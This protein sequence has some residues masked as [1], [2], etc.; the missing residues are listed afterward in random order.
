[1]KKNL[2]PL[3]SDT[4]FTFCTTAFFSFCVARFY[5]HSA[6]AAFAVSAIT[7]LTVSSVFYLYRR[8][9]QN[10]RYNDLLKTENTEKFCFHLA[11]DS[12]ESNTALVA[13]CLFPQ[14][15]REAEPDGGTHE[16]Q[17]L[18]PQ[19]SENEIRGEDCRVWVNF[20][21]EK[22]GAD[23]LAPAIR[24]DCEN[25]TIYANGFT[26]DAIRLA[27]AFGIRLKTGTDLYRIAEMRGLVPQNMLTPPEKTRSV[28]EKLRLRIRRESWKGY[29]LSGC[30]MLLFSLF[31]VFPVYYLVSGGILLFVCAL[32]RFFG[33]KTDE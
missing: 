30:L 14:E 2:I 16:R 25:K 19:I 7:A 1:M 18:P 24:T 26:D 6:A 20:S 23:A 11:A 12:A 21:F 29:L 28:R 22:A 3:I 10:K 9:R 17:K 33:K 8:K 27:E 4:V 32:V 15:P 13:A 5:L 31:T